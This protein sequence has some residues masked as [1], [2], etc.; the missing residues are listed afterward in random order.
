MLTFFLAGLT[1]NLLTSLD[2]ALTRIPVL[3]AAARSRR[4]RLA[5]T[6]GNMLAVTLAVL[7]AFLLSRFLETLPNTQYII[8][9]LIFILAGIVYFDLLALKPPAKINAEVERS[10]WQPQRLPKLIGLGLV[11]TFI[12][13]IDDMFALAPLFLHGWQA[14]L[15]ALAG[16]YTAALILAVMVIFFAHK[17]AVLPHKRLLA[18]LS[19]IIFGLLLLFG[20]I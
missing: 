9:G 8:A 1:I 7:L 12:T 18:T 10:K 14:S 6:L 13:M 15:A 20:I 5:F 2:D 11:M 17:L 16:I 19:L 3:T 4:G